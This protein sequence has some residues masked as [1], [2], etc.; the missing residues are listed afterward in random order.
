MEVTITRP[1][2]RSGCRART[3]ARDEPRSA[4]INLFFDWTVNMLET[5]QMVD[6]AVSRVQSSLPSTAQIQTHRLDFSSF[7]IIGYSLTS[8]TV[9]QTDLW[10]LAT[11]E[12]KPRLNSLSGVASVLVQ[13]GQ[14]PEFHVTVDPSEMLRTGVA[15]SDILA[16][17]NRTNIIDSPGL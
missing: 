8:K 10:E 6:A 12:I 13:G 1:R 3:S 15:L 14:R 17:I 9:S 16:A 2:R 5:L 11:Y 7:P 4:E